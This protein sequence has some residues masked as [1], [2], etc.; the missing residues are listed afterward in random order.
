MVGEP[1]GEGSQHKAACW[2]HRFAEVMWQVGPL[3]VVEDAVVF[4]FGATGL[5]YHMDHAILTG[6]LDRGWSQS[7]Q[8][9]AHGPAQLWMSRPLLRWTQRRAGPRLLREM[10]ALTVAVP[11]PLHVAPM[12]ERRSRATPHIHRAWA[13]PSPLASWN[14]RGPMGPQL[15][16]HQFPGPSLCTIQR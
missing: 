6:H 13:H 2:T 4:A 11:G 10:C 7:R 1:R 9:L 8:G 3:W 12:A 15:C 5:R 14:Q 16:T